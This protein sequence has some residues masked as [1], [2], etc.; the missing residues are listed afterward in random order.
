MENNIGKQRAAPSGK[1]IDNID[2]I[3]PIPTS[4]G[5]GNKRVLLASYET[6]T[7]L[8]QIAITDLMEGE[9]SEPHVH[10]TM[11]ELFLVTEGEVII[12]IEE[13]NYQLAAG[14]FMQVCA[15]THHSIKAMTHAKILTIG[16]ASGG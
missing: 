9:E 2:H 3:N 10:S 5:I 13:Q 11:E 8:T 12:R 7:K 16:C 14:G 15:G 1:L 6:S 4:H